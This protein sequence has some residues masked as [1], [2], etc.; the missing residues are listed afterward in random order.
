MIFNKNILL[1]IILYLSILYSYAQ[2]ITLEEIWSGKFYPKTISGINSLK[3]GKEYT[4]LTKNG[5]EKYSYENFDK[6]CT[7]ISGNYSDY[8]FN[9]N[10][11]CLLLEREFSSLY[12]HSKVGIY[13][14]YNIKTQSLFEVFNKRPI[15]EP[16]FSPDG[17]QL[18]FVYENNIYYQEFPS[19]KITQVTHDGK[20]NKIIN[21]ISDWVYE[22]EFGHVRNFEW[23]PDGKNIAYIHFDESHVKEVNIP[24]YETYLYPEHLI[25]KYPK[26]GEANSNVALNIYNVDKKEINTISLSNYE[27][28]YIIKIRFS[29]TGDLFAITSNRLQNKINII[30]INPTNFSTKLLVLESSTTWVDTD[31]L[32]IEFLPDGNFILNSEKNDYN[33]LYL[34]NYNGQLTKQLTKGNWEVTHIYG[35]DNKNSIVYFQSN[36]KGSNN[37]IISSVNIK[38]GK[39]KILTDEL[40]THDAT[41]STDFSFFIDKFST[42]NTPP[43]FTLRNNTGNI[44]K[45]LEDNSTLLSYI[46]KKEIK[47]MEFIDIPTDNGINLKSYIIKPKHFNSEKKYPVLMYVYGGPGSQTI[48]NSW[49]PFNY[50]WHQMLAQEGYIIVSVDGR[51]T[52][53]RGGN[54]KK[55]TYKQLG[56][57]ELEDQIAAAKWLQTQSFVDANRIGIWG[58]S[59]GGYLTS[60]CM[61]KSN[62]LFKIGIAVAPVTNWRFYDTIYT[63]RFLQTPQE[64]PEGYDENS[65]INFAGN[66]QGKFLLIH[67]TADDNVHFQNSAEM[68]KALIQNG[69]QVDT[70]IYPDKDHSIY[71][72]NTRYHLYQ[73]MTNY[74]KSNL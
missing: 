64:N 43:L 38:N 72:G 18:A 52:G 69:K 41:F 73:K 3:N 57:L 5:I 14:L 44:I 51:G 12:R 35:V 7:I 6:I 56:K 37:R 48:N 2:K 61:T 55:L 62:G 58:W 19:L 74:I 39:Q 36:E 29:S 15:Q 71:G 46:N 17:T 68:I 16:I 54:F 59:F 10:E 34:Y 11:D 24:L 42:A 31:K 20:K 26:A 66:L 65:P 40:G 70:A 22:E 63:E 23:S 13:T 67:G 49:D 27:N 1:S 33:H 21:G 53:G 60:L 47:K 50:W 4:I 25:Y 32:Y 9:N 8:Q 30:R 45:T 28:Y